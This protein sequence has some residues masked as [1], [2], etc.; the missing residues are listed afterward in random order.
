MNLFNKIK[1]KMKSA[2]FKVWW[3]I[4]WHAPNILPMLGRDE[5]KYRRERDTQENQ[6][7]TPPQDLALRMHAISAIEFYGPNEIDELYKKLDKLNWAVDTYPDRITPSD[8]IQQR[9][10]YGSGIASLSIGVIIRAKQKAKYRHIKNFAEIPRE[11]DYLD[12]RIIQVTPSLTAIAI[13]F[14]LN[15]PHIEKYENELRKGRKT[16]QKRRSRWMISIESPIHQKI[17]ALE[18]A[19][20]KLRKIAIR[21]IWQN[22]PG[23]FCNLADPLAFPTMEIISSNGFSLLQRD[24]DGNHRE[25]EWRRILSHTSH[26]D[27]WTHNEQPGIQ[28][29]FAESLLKR[30]ATHLIASIDSSTI[31]PE[32]LN[33]YGGSNPESS[34]RYALSRLEEVLIHSACISYTSEQLK[35]FS[36]IKDQINAGRHKNETIKVIQ[37][38]KSFFESTLGTR[39]ISKELYHMSSKSFYLDSGLKAFCSE[40]WRKKDARNLSTEAREHLG[41]LSK[42]VMDE[43]TALRSHLEQMATILN[44][45]ESIAAQKRMEKLTIIAV[46]VAAGSLWAALPDLTNLAERAFQITSLLIQA[47][48]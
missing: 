47:S 37:Q 10:S 41:F 31:P 38:I 19:R 8:W 12:V 26:Y 48:H 44:T 24:N 13:D 1:S 16:F 43:D 29:T 46:L 45:A 40:H 23:M 17:T 34:S 15:S 25:E 5:K 21:W 30:S 33:F 42:R 36:T 18:G 39:A 6:D 22:L 3:K 14:Y 4:R 9:R 2:I 7:T 32:E 35:Y 20:D 11:I 28:F 27:I